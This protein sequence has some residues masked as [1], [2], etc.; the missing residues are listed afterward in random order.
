MF[1]TK[2]SRHEREL[3]RFMVT[4]LQSKALLKAFTNNVLIQ[5][6]Q[7]DH[8]IIFLWSYICIFEENMSSDKP[9]EFRFLRRGRRGN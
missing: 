6:I 1:P 2:I 9:L 4:E 7:F 8:Q 5:T 3:A